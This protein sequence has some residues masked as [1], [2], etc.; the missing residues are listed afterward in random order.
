MIR[1]NPWQNGITKRKNRTIVEMA[2][3]MLNDKKLPNDYWA[4]VVVVSVHILNISLA[5]A[6]RNIT[7]M[8]H[9]FIENLMSGI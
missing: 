4:E 5:K 9:G 6:V 8:K 2:R 1:R 7:P 3:S